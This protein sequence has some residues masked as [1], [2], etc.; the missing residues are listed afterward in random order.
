MSF[1]LNPLPERAAKPRQAGIT[2]S[3]DKGLS[4]RQAEDFVSVA[5]AHVDVI[6]L[7]FGTSMVTP[8][9]ARQEAGKI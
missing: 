4:V 7:G 1:Q 5:G 6:K 8:K 9:L 3:M 2:M